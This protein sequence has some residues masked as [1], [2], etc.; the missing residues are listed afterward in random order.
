MFEFNLD[1]Y[2][3]GMIEENEFGNKGNEH[4]DAT[5]ILLTD[6]LSLEQD[7]FEYNY[8]F[9]DCW[10]HE[11]TLDQPVEKEGKDV[12]PKCISGQL[13]CPPEDCGGIAG[14]NDMQKIL[15]DK[16]HPDHKETKNWVGKNYDPGSFVLAKVNRQLKQLQKYI[17]RWNSPD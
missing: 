14:F 16:K 8:D 1:G 7:S 5:K 10:V 6:I 11:I 12:Y 3:I 13:N 17:S 15:K 2:R 9:G 4:L